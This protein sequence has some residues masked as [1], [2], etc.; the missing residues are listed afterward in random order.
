LIWKEDPAHKATLGWSTKA[1]GDNH[2]VTLRKDGSD[3]TKKVE[4]YRN[5]RYDDSKNEGLEVYYHHAKLADLDP[6]TKYHVQMHSDGEA[7]PEFYFVTA[8]VEDVPVQL[9]YGGDSRTDRKMR[10]VVNERI[11]R[12]FEES[13]NVIAF[14]HGGDYIVDG[15]RLSQWLEWMS[16]HELTVAEDGRLLPM[17]PARGNHDRG[18]V[19]NQVF[20]FPDDDRENWYATD[21]GPQVRWITL[22]TETSTSG[23]QAEFLERELKAA[24]PDYRWLLAQYH[25][26]AWPAVKG[27]SAAYHAWVPMFEKYHVDMVCESDGHVMKRTVPIRDGKRDE[28]GVVYVGEGGLGVPQRSPKS[29]RWFLQPPGFSGVGHHVQLITFDEDRLRCQTVRVDG[30]IAD[31]YSRT[32]RSGGN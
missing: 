3:E 11:R 4:A 1:Q 23:D 9:I 5:G 25:R 27:P 26:P 16:A 24:R 31:D 29:G 8:P 28:T 10:R 17:L 18:E 22:N 2:W 12:I 21:L 13:P 19:I 30:K 32:P 20:D 14:A 7:S 15:H 6:A